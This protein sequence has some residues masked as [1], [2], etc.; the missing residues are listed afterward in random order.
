MRVAVT[1]VE[2]TTWKLPAAR[3]TPPPSPVSPVAVLKFV[4]VRVTGTASV[5]VAGCV[6]AFGVIEV[7]VGPS[8]VKLVVVEL[9]FVAVTTVTVRAVSAAAVVIVHSALTVVAVGAGV[10]IEQVTPVPETA[11]DVAPARLVPDRVTGMFVDPRRPDAGVLEVSV[12]T[13]IVSLVVGLPPFGVATVTVL[14]PAAALAKDVQFVVTVDAV[15]V[16]VDVGVVQVTPVP[17]KVTAVAPSRSAPVMVT[18][19]AVVL[20]RSGFGLIELMDGAST[21][22]APLS[23]IVPPGATTVTLREVRAAVT[24]IVNVAVIVVEVVETMFAVT[25]VPEIVTWLAPARFV[26]VIVTVSEVPR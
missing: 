19:V 1:V 18:V 22:N 21:V 3:V 14:A 20:R 11:I 4:P 12:G 17:E 26:P 25:P 5:P 6:A 13:A 16:P 24:V 10:V 2:F 9:P 15:T 23:V 7:S 8:T